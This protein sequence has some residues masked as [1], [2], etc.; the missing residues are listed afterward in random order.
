LI[1]PSVQRLT[2]VVSGRVQGVGFRYWV[3]RQAEALGLAGTATNL[4][5][6]AVEVV[7][8]GPRA[9]CERLAAL[10]RE[11]G[12]ADDPPPGFV[13]KVEQSWAVASGLTGFRER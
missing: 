4:A 9:D 12:P 3:R 8:E 7:V 11:D 10:L 6:G 1:D 13:G 5:N 2:A